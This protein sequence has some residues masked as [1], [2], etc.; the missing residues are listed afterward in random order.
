MAQP[1]QVLRPGL[2]VPM[3]I[4]NISPLRL[5]IFYLVPLRG[6]RG[7]LDLLQGVVGEATH[8]EE[9]EGTLTPGG[10]ADRKSSFPRGS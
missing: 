7:N 1:T 5:Y 8:L 10:G 9:A 2:A 3:Q 4:L 6:G